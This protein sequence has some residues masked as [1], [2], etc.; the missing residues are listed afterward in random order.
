MSK[1]SDIILISLSTQTLFFT[2]FEN[3]MSHINDWYVV[4]YSS[5]CYFLFCHFY[6]Y[7]KFESYNIFLS[8]LRK[9]ITGWLPVVSV[10]ISTSN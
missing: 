1:I 7:I 6:F 4:T 5:V 2:F 9:K 8:L 3:F 10:L